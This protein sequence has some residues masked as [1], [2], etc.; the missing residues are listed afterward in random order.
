[1]LSFFLCRKLLNYASFLLTIMKHNARMILQ[2]LHTVQ[3]NRIQG[4]IQCSIS[5][6]EQ[7]PYG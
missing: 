7:P 4:G 5:K 1:M 3:F 6:T 2:L